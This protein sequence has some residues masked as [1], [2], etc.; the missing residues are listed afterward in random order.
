MATFKSGDKYNRITLIKL[1]HKNKNYHQYWLCECDCGVKKVVNASSVKHG[2][3][4]SCGCLNNELLKKRKPNLSHGYANKEK[5]YEV[6]KNM[7]RRCKDKNNNRYEFYGGKGIVVCEDWD[8]DYLSF[9][10]WAMNNGY[11]DNLTIDRIDNN[12]NYEPENCRWATMKE[13]L[14]NQSRNRLLTYKGETKTMSEWATKLNITY[15]AINHR[16]Q[17]D[18]S[19]ERI[20]NTPMRK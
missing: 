16:V 10:N 4:K 6:W 12:G 17:R 5:L 8:N 2:S 13:Q 9:R 15:G 7:K 11:K 14:N 3:I 18:W 19:M 20:V 1:D